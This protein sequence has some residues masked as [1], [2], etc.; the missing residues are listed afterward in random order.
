MD[1]VGRPQ[2]TLW[3]Q[4]AALCTTPLAVVVGAQ[5]GIEAVAVGFVLSQLIAVEIPMLII[6][7]SE[8]QI[9]LSSVAARLYGVAAATLIMATTCFAARLVLADLGVDLEE[10][11]A[12]TIGLGLLVYPITVWWLAPDIVRRA[13]GI[14]R[15]LVA[16]VLGPRRRAL[17]QTR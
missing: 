3:T 2:V 12:L 15:G 13:I 17:L 9:S 8:L 6:V 4:L 14:C 7:L 1:A 5:W 16:K 11:A 10:R